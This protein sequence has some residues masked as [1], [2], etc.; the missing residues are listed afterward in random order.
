MPYG[1]AGIVI[2][3]LGCE[4][5]AGDFEVKEWCFGGLAPQPDLRMCP[6]LW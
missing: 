6:L 5:E 3:V 2:A 1:R 4:T